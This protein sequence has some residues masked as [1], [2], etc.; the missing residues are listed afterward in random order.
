MND[1]SGVQPRLRAAGALAVPVLAGIAYLAAF[2]APTTFVLVNS[3]ALVLAALW[4]AVAPGLAGLWPRRLIALGCIVLLFLPLVTGPTT[5]GISR[6]LPLGPFT[7]HAG[8]LAVP[9]LVAF[10]AIETDYAPPLLLTALIAAFLQPDAATGFA[11]TFAAVGLYHVTRDWKIAVVAIIGF[12]ASLIMAMRGELPPQPF[13]ERIF[14]DL[15]FAAPIAA[16]LLFAA[17]VTGFFLILHVAP[18]A[19]EVRYTIAGSLFGFAIMAIMSHYPTP[20]VGYGA[21]PILG[22]GLALGLNIR[23]PFAPERGLS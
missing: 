12:F 2:G 13:V 10:A 7:L 6:W 16:A 19:R 14:A 15:I 17:L 1:R 3:I 21:A 5:A 11:L 8:M 23:N 20:L 18:A 4:I 22:F 9:V